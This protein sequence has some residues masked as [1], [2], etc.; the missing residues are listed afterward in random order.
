MK[1]VQFITYKGK[2][3]LLEDFTF[4][5][6]GKEYGKLIKETQK[7]IAN[8]PLKSVLA[9]FDA[10]GCSFTKES[11]KQ[12]LDFTKA[13]TPYIKGTTVI[14]ISGLLQ[15]ALSAVT[16]FAGRDFHEFPTRE[17]AMDYLVTLE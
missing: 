16:D 12:T 14:G 4:M 7:M 11:L 5:Q 9:V 10:T 1:R 17:E 15:I 3:I 2:R 13:N 8:E 6:P